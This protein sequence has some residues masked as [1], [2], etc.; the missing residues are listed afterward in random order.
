MAAGGE[1]SGG[2]RERRRVDGREVT[3]NVRKM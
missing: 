2:Y 3:V 1:E